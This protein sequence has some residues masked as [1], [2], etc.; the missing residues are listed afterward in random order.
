MHYQSTWQPLQQLLA[1]GLGEAGLTLIF[2]KLPQD[3]SNN[4]IRKAI[5]L[6]DMLELYGSGQKFYLPIIIM[7]TSF[8]LYSMGR[9]NG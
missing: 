2:R 7:H 1:L 5:T 8:H 6:S 9:K 3:F 4:L